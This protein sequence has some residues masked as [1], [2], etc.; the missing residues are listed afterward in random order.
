MKNSALVSRPFTRTSTN[1]AKR[2]ERLR[3]KRWGDL[4]TFPAAQ[5]ELRIHSRRMAYLNR[6]LFLA[7]T[8]LKTNQDETIARVNKLMDAENQR[9]EKAMERLKTGAPAAPLSGREHRSGCTVKTTMARSSAGRSG[10]LRQER[11]TCQDRRAGSGRFPEF[12]GFAR[13][14]RPSASSP[15]AGE[16]ADRRGFRRGSRKRNHSVESRQEARRVG[17]TDSD[18]VETAVPKSQRILGFSLSCLALSV[19]ACGR[20]ERSPESTASSTQVPI[21]GSSSSAVSSASA[22]PVAS[23]SAVT[24]GPPGPLNVLM[25]HHRQLA[26]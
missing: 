18:G 10:L 4:L 5:E 7:E 3:A 16:R 26:R 8:E 23:V 25:P 14:R 17:K 24:A 19:A 11:R 22:T 6:A 1:A 21:S 13:H 2:T 9:H 20:A 15:S 12:S